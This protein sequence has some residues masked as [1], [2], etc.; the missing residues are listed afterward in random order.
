[1]LEL[2]RN[3]K[4]PLREILIGALLACAPLMA[5]QMAVPGS[6]N[7]VEGQVTLNG[8]ALTSGAIGSAQVEAGR[9][10]ETGLGKAEVLLTPGVFFR[11]GDNSALR[12]V[13]PGLS[14]TQVELLR[15]QGMLEV[16]E[17]FKDNHLTVL[18][19]GAS[20]L[21]DKRGLYA[22]NAD[23]PKVSVFDGEA[24]VSAQDRQ[25]KLK[26]GKETSLVG[27]LHAQGFDRDH[28]D[29]LYSWSR[30][31]SEYEAQAGAQ[32]AQTVVVNGGP[33][34]GAGWYWDPWWSSYAFV[35]GDG[36]LYSPF[37]WGFYSPFAVYPGIG[38]VYGRGFVGRGFVHGRPPVAAF[39]GGQ[40][41]AARSSFGGGF[42]GG[43]T[44]A[45]GFHGGGG[46]R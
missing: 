14:N 18:D 29:E 20:T 22:F 8:S 13:S 45:G 21:I 40:A 31:R 15:G 41:P 35:P 19:H 28:Q 6:V 1:M 5:G 39:R 25:I 23:N 38:F 30:L 9:V 34:W 10:L 44:G 17:L 2:A 4:W 32:Y 27:T 46:R 11:L 42:H 33:W 7:Y 36:I 12:M 26:K 16:A 24:S 37:G 43:G 3:S